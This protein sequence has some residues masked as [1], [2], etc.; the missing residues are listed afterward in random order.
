MIDLELLNRKIEK[1]DIPRP[2]YQPV[3]DRCLVFQV[4]TVEKD[5]FATVVSEAT[6]KEVKLYRP[7]ETKDRERRTSPRGVLVAAGMKALEILHGHGINVGDTVWFARFSPWAHEINAS[8]KVF[9]VIRA[10]EISG[11]EEL[12]DKFEQGEAKHV[13]EDDG[14]WALEMKGD[15]LLRTDP[16]EYL[17]E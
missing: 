10:G 9:N 17:D 7:E 15:K 3:F 6:G 5:D 8:S 11:S 14:H 13:I 12:M 2:H 4:N 1:Y 16:E